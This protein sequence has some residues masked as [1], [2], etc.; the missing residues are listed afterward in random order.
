MR[1]AIVIRFVENQILGQKTHELALASYPV[2][3]LGAVRWVFV[4][5][6][7]STYHEDRNKSLAKLQVQS[8]KLKTRNKVLQSSGESHR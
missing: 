4:L 5:V 6:L 3:L 1:A 7:Q 8:L 2:W